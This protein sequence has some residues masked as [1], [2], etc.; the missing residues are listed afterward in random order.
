MTP[1]GAEQPVLFLCLAVA[2]IGAVYDFFIP[3]T[4]KDK[5]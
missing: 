3:E 5:P 1:E 2:L 4:D